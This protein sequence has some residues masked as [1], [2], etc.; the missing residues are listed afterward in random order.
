MAYRKVLVS[1][2]NLGGTQ[3]L[4]AKLRDFVEKSEAGGGGGVAWATTV[5]LKVDLKLQT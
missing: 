3:A 4:K 2:G 1:P 5:Q